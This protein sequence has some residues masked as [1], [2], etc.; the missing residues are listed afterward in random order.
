MRAHR[1]L[2]ARE[3][4]STWLAPIWVAL[5]SLVSL[6]LA[7]FVIASWTRPVAQPPDRPARSD[8]AADS[9]PVEGVLRTPAQGRDT[10]G[11]KTWM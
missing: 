3:R 11:K 10:G 7:G 8:A 5:L 9:R 1:L 2:F 4:P 6:G